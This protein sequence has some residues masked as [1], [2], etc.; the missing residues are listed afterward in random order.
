MIL[1][2]SQRGGSKQLALHLL[3]ATDNE[4]VEIHELRGFLG[5][6]LPSALKEIDAISRGTRAKQFMF[7]LSLNPPAEER[8]PIHV[9]EDAIERIETRLGLQG[10]PRA[11]VFHEKDGRRHAHVVW[12]RIR[13]DRMTAINLPHF[14]LKL[15]DVSREL[16]R[17]HGWR[18]PRGLVD[19]RERDPGTFTR[20]EWEQA[21]RGGLDARALKGLFQDCW[22]ASDSPQAFAQALRGRGYV[23][24]RGDRR[25]YVA[26]D[27]RGEV[28]ALAKWLGVRTKEVRD[29]LGDGRA[30]PS[31]DEARQQL[32]GRMTAMLERH[33]ADAEAAFEKQRTALSLKRAQL[34]ERQRR[35][36]ADLEARQR[37]RWARETAE[38]ARR[39]SSGFRGLWDKLTGVHARM[40]RENESAAWQAFLRDRR[41]RDAL[42]ERHLDERQAFHQV[43]REAREAHS[44]GMAELHRDMAQFLG[45]DRPQEPDLTRTFRDASRGRGDRGRDRG[46]RHER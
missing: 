23:L 7:S 19:S 9:F 22:Q 2:G 46:P 35:E 42:I 25:G 34:I 45:L 1:K 17:D 13:G 15:R 18:L 41:E 14:K 37:E 11:V 30:L 38:R 20:A 44:Q 43:V 31:V 10:Q 32:A 29:R 36:R 24:A 39:I 40:A 6:D 12:S 8:V 33:A 3:K 4:H 28:Y 26:V 21:K 16:F 5:D 27:F